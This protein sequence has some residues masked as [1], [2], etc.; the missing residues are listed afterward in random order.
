MRRAPRSDRPVSWQPSKVCVLDVEQLPERIDADAVYG[1][2]WALVR[3]GGRPRGMVELPLQSGRVEPRR[4]LDSIAELPAASTGPPL[5]LMPDERLPKISVVVPTAMERQSTLAR[6][7]RSLTQLEYPASLRELIVV[8]NRPGGELFRTPGATV[9]RE[10]RR[11]VSA[12]RNR[13]LAL[14]AGEI[15]AF[16]DDDAEA[17]PLWL[18]AIAR[19]LRDHPDEAA[20]TGLVMP[21]ELDTP[22]QAAFERYYDGFSPRV[23]EAVSNR[24]RQPGRGGPLFRPATVESIGPDGLPRGEFSLYL[25]GRLGAGVNMAFRTAELREVG[26]FELALGPGTIAR[27]GEELATL[28]RLLWRGCAIGFEP[29]ALVWHSHRREHTE[30]RRQVENYGLGTVAALTALV[31]EDPSHLGR[32]LAG[33]PGLARAVRQ[34]ARRKRDSGPP[35]VVTR[36]LA[37]LELRGMALGPL[38]Y[39]RSRRR[40]GR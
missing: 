23:Y 2:V 36:E 25:T 34:G 16:I 30:L 15:V 28:A 9:V 11:G 14:A 37:L 1:S 27:N 33:L 5:R 24:L 4:L 18:L 31:I 13:G 38:A 12:A 6:C 22:A 26:G 8:D 19:R 20:V 29:A 40:E 7:L 35:A 32:M 3:E 10:P 17:D 21:R 39:A